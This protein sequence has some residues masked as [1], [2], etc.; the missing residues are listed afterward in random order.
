[1]RV[2]ELAAALGTTADTVRYYT[3]IGFLKPH[4]DRFNGYR[5]Y[6]GEARQRLRFILSARDL[7]FSVEDI[8]QLLAEAGRGHSPCPHTRELI[9]RRLVESERRLRE[10]QALHDRM[11]TAALAWEALPDGEPDGHAICRLIEDFIPA[12][13]EEDTP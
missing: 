13:R 7:G 1:M 10:M 2:A 12:P 5:D 6:D 9:A 3:R 8:G 4:K 11:R